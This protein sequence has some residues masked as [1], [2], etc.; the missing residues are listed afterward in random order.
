MMKNGSGYYIWQSTNKDEHLALTHARYN[1]DEDSTNQNELEHD[2]K[3][4]IYGL[5]S[6][7]SA[8]EKIEE[9]R[10]FLNS[11]TKKAKDPAY[12]I[13]EAIISDY[14]KEIDV[15]DKDGN[16]PKEVSDFINSA[17]LWNGSTNGFGA[18]IY[19]ADLISSSSVSSII[20]NKPPYH[21]SMDEDPAVSDFIGGS[22]G[23]DDFESE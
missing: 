19:K 2:K 17:V 14:L 10:K 23:F 21:Y 11:V 20:D 9:N 8:P 18:M 5:L 13:K 3:K 12:K 1:E 4:A 6:D 16:M 7:L 15:L 22:K